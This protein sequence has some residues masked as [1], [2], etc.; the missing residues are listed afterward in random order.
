VF[1]GYAYSDALH[2]IENVRGGK[3]RV[4]FTMRKILI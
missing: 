3:S 1:H 2:S 4:S